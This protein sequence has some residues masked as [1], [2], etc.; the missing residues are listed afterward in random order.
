MRSG[1]VLTQEFRMTQ[2]RHLIVRAADDQSGK[3]ELGELIHRIERLTRH[4]VAVK[5]RGARF[6]HPLRR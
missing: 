6:H 4:Q 1:D 2:G 5:N 3:R